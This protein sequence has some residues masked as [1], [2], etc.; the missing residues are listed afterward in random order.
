LSLRHP[1]WWD[2]L[3]PSSYIAV[4]LAVLLCTAMWLRRSAQFRSSP[5]LEAATIR[6]A[7]PA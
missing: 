1:G 6:A 3:M 4:Y 2:R 5:S 7:V